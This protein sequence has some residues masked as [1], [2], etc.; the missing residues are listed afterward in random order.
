MLSLLIIEEEQL[1]PR[2]GQDLSRV[3][4]CLAV[5]ESGPKCP[6]P[7]PPVCAQPHAAC[8]KCGSSILQAEILPCP[9]SFCTNLSSSPEE[10]T[11]C[12]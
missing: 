2:E 9:P 3:T 4:L 5:S 11:Y 7:R 8:D 6:V 10:G 1:D 12:Y